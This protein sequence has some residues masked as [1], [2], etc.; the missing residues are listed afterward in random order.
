MRFITTRRR[1]DTPPRTI[2]NYLQREWVYEIFRGAAAAVHIYISF[3]LVT[4]KIKLKS[5]I[6]YIINILSV[7]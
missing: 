5:F 3:I 7:G 6:L 4:S 1:L 2:I